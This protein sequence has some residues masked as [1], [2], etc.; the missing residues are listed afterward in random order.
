MLCQGIACRV[1]VLAVS[2]S[3]F[4][5]KIWC[6]HLI[7]WHVVPICYE[8]NDDYQN[9][10]DNNSEN[11]GRNCNRSNSIRVDIS[12]NSAVVE[13]ALLTARLACHCFRGGVK[14]KWSKNVQAIFLKWTITNW[15]LIIHDVHMSAH[16]MIYLGVLY[17]STFQDEVLLVHFT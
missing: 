15:P 14:R 2:M 3:T 16:T 5:Q 11:S 7:C 12:S 4:Q 1:I 8:K 9:S 17:V 6:I 13:A 10:S